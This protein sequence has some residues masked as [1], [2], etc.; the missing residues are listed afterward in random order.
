MSIVCAELNVAWVVV[1]AT[2]RDLVLHHG[3]GAQIRR[4]TQ[5]IDFAVEVVDWNAFESI[6]SK[7]LEQGFRETRAQHQLI[8]P[9]N[10]SIDLVPFG[11]IEK[12]GSIIE[13]PPGGEIAMNV[14]GFAEACEHADEV[15]LDD[16]TNLVVPVATPP[17]M[18]LLKLIAWADRAADMPRKDAT[19]IKYIL[20][21]Y[22]RIPAILDEVYGEKNS[23]IMAT[24]DW[25]LTLACS[26]LLGRHAQKIASPETSET[27]R[28][29][30]AGEIKNLSIETLFA[31]MS[32]NPLEARRNQQM[33]EAC[34]AGFKAQGSKGSEKFDPR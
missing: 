16:Q 24:Y 1:G 34:C 2:A 26:H 4:A 11:Q 19:D 28:R 15:L 9:G 31:E 5:D 12:A 10:E 22:E 3:Y 13:W 29:L 32:Q 14:L 25:D 23:M 20:E 27:V 30:F 6:K 17:G 21:S 18:T 33:L 8:G 7:L